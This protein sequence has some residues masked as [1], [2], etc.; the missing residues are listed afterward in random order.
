[1]DKEKTIVYG[2]SQG[3]DFLSPE[4]ISMP[5][6]YSTETYT[7]T[8]ERYGK[9]FLSN[10]SENVGVVKPLRT[11]YYESESLGQNITDL[12][13]GQEDREF[14]V[15]DHIGEYGYWVDRFSHC[16]SIEDVNRVKA[17]IDWDRWNDEQMSKI[18]G[19]VNFTFGLMSGFMDPINYIPWFN[20]AS[21]AKTVKEA[22]VQ[23]AGIGMVT[24][25]AQEYLIKANSYNYTDDEYA[26]N[27][28]L[29][30][31]F[32][33]GVAGAIHY[34]RGMKNVTPQDMKETVDFIRDNNFGKDSLKDHVDAI[35]TLKNMDALE[36]DELYQ[37]VSKDI[38][39]LGENQGIGS[40]GAAMVTSTPHEVKS[41]AMVDTVLKA[42]ASFDPTTSLAISPVRASRNFNSKVANSWYDVGGTSVDNIEALAIQKRDELIIAA[43]KVNEAYI[44]FATDMEDPSE[45]RKFRARHEIGV[46]ANTR[47]VFDEQVF[48]VLTTGKPSENAAVNEVAKIEDE[49]RKELGAF[50]DDMNAKGYD[51]PKSIENWFG[52]RFDR[53]LVMENPKEFRSLVYDHLTEQARILR[54]DGEQIKLQENKTGNERAIEK[55]KEDIY[56]KTKD[57]ENGLAQKIKKKNTEQYYA[58]KNLDESNGQIHEIEREIDRTLRSINQTDKKLLVLAEKDYVLPENRDVAR[59]VKLGVPVEKQALRLGEWLHERNILIDDSHNEINSESKLLLKN[60]KG[61]EKQKSKKIIVKIDDLSELLGQH[62][63]NNLSAYER[64]DI[65]RLVDMLEDDLGNINPVYRQD[66]YGKLSYMNTVGQLREYL[67]KAGFN[68]NKMSVEQID[69]AL[70]SLNNKGYFKIGVLRNAREEWLSKLSGDQNKTLKDQIKRLDALREKRNK[71]QKTLDDTKEELSSLRSQRDQFKEQIKQIQGSNRHIDRKY[72]YNQELLDKLEGFRGYDAE[73]NVI[74]ISGKSFSDITDDIV[75]SIVTPSFKTS[76]IEFDINERGSLLS[77]NFLTGDISKFKPF[78]DFSSEHFFSALQKEFVDLNLIKTFGDVNAKGAID[79]IKNSWN[80][81]IDDA[82]KRIDIYSKAGD[83]KNV[84]KWTKKRDAAYKRKERDIADANLLVGRLRGTSSKQAPAL[85]GAIKGYNVA[86]SLSKAAISSLPDLG[87]MSLH[88]G[89]EYGV[90]AMGRYG[91]LL[92]NPKTYQY[93]K[94]IPEFSHAVIEVA[95]GMRG[96]SFI[97]MADGAM[98]ADKISRVSK[99][100][101]DFSLRINLMNWHNFVSKLVTGITYENKIYNIGQ[102][103]ISGKSV[104]ARELDF[105][106]NSGLSKEDIIDITKNIDRYGEVKVGYKYGNLTRWENQELAKKFGRSINR[107]MDLVIATPGLDAPRW[108]ESPWLSALGQFKTFVFASTNRNTINALQRYR[109]ANTYAAIGISWALGAAAV[110][111]K[112][113]ISGRDMPDYEEVMKDGFAQS[114]ILG[115]MEEGYNL[116]NAMTMGAT[117]RALYNVTG[118]L[119]GQEKLNRYQKDRMFRS[120]FGPTITKAYSFG[121]LVGSIAD[122]KPMTRQ[123]MYNAKGLIPVID[124]IYTSYVLNNYINEHSD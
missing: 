14:D 11:L 24:N 103:L 82:I 75:E 122:D 35:N 114:G 70:T 87:S 72:K 97:E 76:N 119:I 64:L 105:I 32:G 54:D 44:K 85:V 37:K 46:G 45:F 4:Q 28:A 84:K 100:V 31:A 52:L 25:A 61:N 91:K 53:K 113:A 74:P 18:P 112:A 92:V 106:K 107:M 86:T 19:A 60:Y 102:D 77:R 108:K 83:E 29:G 56:G 34:G 68:W 30:T 116:S 88:L 115:W 9:A 7:E 17:Q 43:D 33:A 21:K 47:R 1:M 79:D 15:Y 40:V 124:S 67:D 48:D 69:N 104:S 98:G 27:V 99:A 121:N 13:L 59:D 95:N 118:G 5:E 101:A 16:R 3:T 50:M 63:W 36:Q 123:E 22:V 26:L 89:V 38:D 110:M 57:D 93:F 51:V 49:A 65:D 41:N 23:T 8:A 117:S 94:D 96:L 42:N 66:D 81:I 120:A 109:D 62:G 20:V 55:I 12:V 80:T 6:D 10:I 73:G 58:K 78:L 39:S 111:A 71:A 90:K 2:Y